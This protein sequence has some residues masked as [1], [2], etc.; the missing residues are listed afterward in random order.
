MVYYEMIHRFCLHNKRRSCG[1]HFDFLVNT[2]TVMCVAAVAY[3]AE[4]PKQWQCNISTKKIIK[5]TVVNLFCISHF[6]V[7]TNG[8]GSGGNVS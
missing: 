6:F 4:I 1:R 7:Q 2:P 5:K 8:L 3:D